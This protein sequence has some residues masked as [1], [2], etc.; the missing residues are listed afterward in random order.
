MPIIR[1]D[2]VV[3]DHEKRVTPAILRLLTDQLGEHFCSEAGGTWVS[4]RYMGLD[5][6]AE[7]G[8]PDLSI[9]PTLV[10]ILQYRRPDRD[11][12]KAEAFKLTQ[13]IAKVLNRP[14]ENVH[15]IYEPHGQGRVV[16]GGELAE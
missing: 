16:F 13:L 2:L 7:N 5:S 10:S 11:Q 15:L 14:A 8:R 12:L 9:R 3:E 6:Y 4:L 1:I